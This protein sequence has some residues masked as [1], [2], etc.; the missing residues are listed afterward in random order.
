[1]PVNTGTIHGI[2]ITKGTINLYGIHPWSLITKQN[3]I[4][5]VV[6][7]AH[8]KPTKEPAWIGLISSLTESQG[9]LYGKIDQNGKMNGNDIVYIYPKAKLALVGKFKDNVMISARKSF[10]TE[11][12]CENDLLQLKFSTPEGNY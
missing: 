12:N 2:V 11:V 8:G 9:F 1:M 7:F 5:Q 4:G 3:G 6:R 10:I